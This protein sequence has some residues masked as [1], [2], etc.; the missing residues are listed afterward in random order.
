MKMYK[1]KKKCEKNRYALKSSFIH[2]TRVTGT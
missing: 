2:D 1:K